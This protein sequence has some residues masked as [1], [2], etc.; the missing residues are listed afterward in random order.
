MAKMQEMVQRGKGQMVGLRRCQ[1]VEFMTQ[2]M[3][4]T[5]HVIGGL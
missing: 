4:G 1:I 3:N 2:N 5:A